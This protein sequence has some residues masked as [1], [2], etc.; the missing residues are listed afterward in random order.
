[1]TDKENFLKQIGHR[2]RESRLNA[3]MSQDELAKKVGYKSRSTINKIESGINDI[4]RSKIVLI[5]RA[6]NTTPAY[7]MGWEDS[8]TKPLPDIRTD[9]HTIA[10]HH[11]GEDW[12]EEELEEIEKFKEFVKSKRNNPK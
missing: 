7:L 1:M 8:D 9:I 3:E 12:T 5:A 4:A 6:L 11:N 10:A 2:I